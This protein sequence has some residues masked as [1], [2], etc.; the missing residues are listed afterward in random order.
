MAA[1]WRNLLFRPYLGAGCFQCQF[2][3]KFK[4]TNILNGAAF[5]LDIYFVLS[6]FTFLF[7]TVLLTLGEPTYDIVVL[8]FRPKKQKL[9]VALPTP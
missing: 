2:L 6:I 8:R 4:P 7:I 9:S 3:V 5:S 1:T